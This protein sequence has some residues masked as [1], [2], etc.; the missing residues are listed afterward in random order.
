MY[1]F[2]GLAVETSGL[3]STPRLLP[4]SAVLMGTMTYGPSSLDE[5]QWLVSDVSSIYPSPVSKKLHSSYS[6]TI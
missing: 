5:D 6:L 4:P 2:P 1:N 3:T